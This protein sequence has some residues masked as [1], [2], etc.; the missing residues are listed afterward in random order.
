MH[1]SDIT[2]VYS[3]CLTQHVLQQEMPN[4]CHSVI[5]HTT[6]HLVQQSDAAV[7]GLQT[8]EV[9]KLEAERAAEEPVRSHH[10]P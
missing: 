5:A 7:S 6:P 4:L 8:A 3:S 2:P 10:R 9:A 1:Q